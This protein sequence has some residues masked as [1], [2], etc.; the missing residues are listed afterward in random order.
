M[1]HAV[2]PILPLP[3]RVDSA[4][5]VVVVLELLWDEDDGIRFIQVMIVPVS[6]GTMHWGRMGIILG[7]R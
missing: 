2:V 4:P 6:M 3:P 5:D 7:Y 1:F